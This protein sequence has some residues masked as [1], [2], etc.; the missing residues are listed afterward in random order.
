MTNE[1][2][3]SLYAKLEA[4]HARQREELEEQ[5]ARERKAL[6]VVGPSLFDLFLAPQPLQRGGGGPRRNYTKIIGD[7][8]PELKEPI[9]INSVINELRTRF[10]MTDINPTSIS[11]A[12]R[13]LS[14]PD[15]PLKILVEGSGR[16]ATTYQKR[17]EEKASF[18]ETA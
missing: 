4:L 8:I 15:G 5:Q 18:F 9:D 17:S 10:Q 13:K 1:E 11:G 3:E 14:T 6:E 12:L 16:R 7:I 2:R